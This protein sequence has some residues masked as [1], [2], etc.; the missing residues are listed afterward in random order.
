MRI[1]KNWNKNTHFQ[2]P[3]PDE[4]LDLLGYEVL[5]GALALKNTPSLLHLVL[6]LPGTPGP[7]QTDPGGDLQVFAVEQLPD[8]AEEGPLDAGY[9]VLLE[10]LVHALAPSHSSQ[11]E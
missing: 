6:E 4:V 1:L 9:A 3:L 7:D 5:D 2:A 10:A 8:L 11:D